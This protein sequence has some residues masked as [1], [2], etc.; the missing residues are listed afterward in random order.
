MFRN[1]A[2]GLRISVL[3]ISLAMVNPVFAQ[4][5]KGQLQEKESSSQTLKTVV[6]KAVKPEEKGPFLPDVQGTKINLGKKTSLIDPAAVHE[7]TNSNYRHALAKVP[8]LLLSEETTP[9]FSVGYRGL[10]PHRGQF[11]QIMKDGIPIH[12]DMFGYPEA[13]YVPPLES[14]D[15]IEFIRGGAALMYGPQPGGALN[16]VTHMP[17]TDRVLVTHA[18]NAFGSD[19]YFSTYESASGTVGQVGYHTYI[20]ERQGD[21]FRDGNSD[22]QVISGGA[23]ITVKQT[24]DTR[25]IFSYDEYHEE[26]GEPG[27]LTR[28]GAVMPNYDTRREFTTR[29]NDR[30]RLERYYGTATLEK[31]FSETTQ[32]DLR[33]YGGHYR[34]FSKRQRGGGFGTLPAGANVNT[35]D[36]EEQDFYNLGFEERLKHTYELFG[37]EHTLS[38]GTLAFLSSSPREE[39]RGAHPQADVGTLRKSSDRGMWYF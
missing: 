36:I 11:T 35:N 39:S 27:G 34:R 16:Y 14:V 6:V 15:R 7:S 32:A 29:P 22:Y 23:K 3:F 1:F 26:H 28:S 12:A 38:L 19:G 30:F 33:V 9:L 25:L 24:E 13:Y 37:E 18:D 20:H 4:D 17:V 10:E 5:Q 31:E 21:G 2:L 8:G